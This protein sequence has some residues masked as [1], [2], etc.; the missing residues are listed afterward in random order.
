MSDHAL[1]QVL[2]AD[3]HCERHLPMIH[4]EFVAVTKEQYGIPA[5]L[6]TASSTAPVTM[7]GFG[8]CGSR[9]GQGPPSGRD[10]TAS[11]LRIGRDTSADVAA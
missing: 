7:T 5:S 6:A 4:P 1:P 2:P 8:V 3:E 10:V 11:N 9:S